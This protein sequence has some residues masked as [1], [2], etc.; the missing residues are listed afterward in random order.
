MADIFDAI[1]SDRIYRKALSLEKAVS[2]IS[3]GLGTVSDPSIVKIF[4]DLYNEGEFDT[5]I[6]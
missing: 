1:T 6:E 4:L 2:I 3:D 5:M